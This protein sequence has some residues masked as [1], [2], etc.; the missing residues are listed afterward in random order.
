MTSG[1]NTSL[2]LESI[3]LVGI[4][5]RNIKATIQNSANV[6]GGR[7]EGILGD[8]AALTTTK[9]TLSNIF[10]I[11][12]LRFRNLSS[13]LPSQSLRF[14]RLTSSRSQ[15]CVSRG[16]VVSEWTCKYFYVLGESS[17]WA[18]RTTEV[19]GGKGKTKQN[20]FRCRIPPEGV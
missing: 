11:I 17:E 7:R 16:D 1:L 14:P 10:T 18:S 13:L 15:P 5:K 12:D 6:K 9:G 4:V 3:R 20:G 2:T 19:K 8:G